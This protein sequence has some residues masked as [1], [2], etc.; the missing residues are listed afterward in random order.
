M[1]RRCFSFRQSYAVFQF[2]EKFSVEVFVH[3]R[4][5]LHDVADLHQSY[6]AF[7]EIR[8]SVG[9]Y[10][11]M[12]AIYFSNACTREFVANFTTPRTGNCT[13]QNKQDCWNSSPI[14]PI[15]EK[16]SKLVFKI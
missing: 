8:K 11:N 4:H 12:A 10:K 5:I 3:P 15:P 7:E 13:Q 2:I 16:K 6:Q 14:S 1:R 9:S